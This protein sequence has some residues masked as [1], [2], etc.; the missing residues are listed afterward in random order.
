VP[1]WPEWV[2]DEAFNDD[3][4]IEIYHLGGVPWHEAPIPGRLH[5]CIAQTGGWYHRRFI[6]RC[7]CGAIRI[8]RRRGTWSERNSRRGRWMDNTEVVPAEE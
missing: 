4:T 3:P 1:N 7:A 5:R 6:E 2:I 8:D